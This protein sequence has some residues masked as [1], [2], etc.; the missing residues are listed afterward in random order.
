MLA[1]EDIQRWT[2]LDE[3]ERGWAQAEQQQRQLGKIRRAMEQLQDI[4]ELQDCITGTLACLSLK[5]YDKAAVHLYRSTKLSSVLESQHARLAVTPRAI[6]DQARAELRRIVQDEF[7]EAVR[8]HD[9]EAIRR[10]FKLF[11]MIGEDTLGLILYAD[12]LCSLISERCKDHQVEKTGPRSAQAKMTKLYEMVAML[13]DHHYPLVETN[14]GPGRMLYIMYRIQREVD[15]QAGML[16]DSFHEEYDVDK[17]ETKQRKQLSVKSAFGLGIDLRL[18]DRFLKELAVMSEK[19]AIYHRFL[20]RRARAEQETLTED[21]IEQRGD[22]KEASMAL[23]DAGLLQNSRLVSTMASLLRHYLPMERYFT[24]KSIAKVLQMDEAGDHDKTSTSLEDVF[25]ILKNCCQRAIA[26]CHVNSGVAGLKLLLYPRDAQ[27]GHMICLNNME[28][29]C[30]YMLK[31]VEKL[32][33]SLAAVGNIYAA[34]DLDAMT[35]ALDSL[36]TLEAKTRIILAQESIEEHFEQHLQ[37]KLYSLVQRLFKP[38]RYLLTEMAYKEQELN[39]NTPSRFIT[40]T[41]SLLAPYYE[42]F[43][44]ANWIAFYKLAACTILEA[45][46]AALYSAR[47]NELGAFQVDK[48]TSALGT[49]LRNKRPAKCP[50]VSERLERLSE[51][52]MLLTIDDVCHQA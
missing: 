33:D 21:E 38:T 9:Q 24:R 36:P 42:T 1:L 15:T 31:L 47:V 23:N 3:L 22:L 14:Y 12:F 45:W 5:D 51:I 18:L 2:T 37:N 48:D 32:R 10:Y 29:A 17:L 13:I 49:F 30:D 16:L 43:T 44:T 41:E 20:E 27:R 26:L 19:T 50:L 7:A 34:D 46:E 4:E 40:E 6:L 28:V 35:R 8:N 39:D 52:N 25:F 11:P